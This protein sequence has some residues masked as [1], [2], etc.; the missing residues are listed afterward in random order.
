MGPTGPIHLAI[1]AVPAAK[2]VKTGVEW[3][4]WHL[5]RVMN[6]LEPELNVTV[7]THRPLDIELQG[8]WRN[9][10]IRAPKGLWKARFSLELLR[11]RP[12]V[13]FVPGDALP[14]IT[15]GKIVTTVHDLAFLSAPELYGVREGARQVRVH[16]RALVRS[17]RLI[18]ISGVTRQELMRH[19]GVD[20]SCIS[21]I[22]L[23]IDHT[24]YRPEARDQLSAVRYKHNLPENYFAFMG[25]LDARKGVANLIRAFL[26][27]RKDQT[28][29]L[30]GAPGESGYDEIHVLAGNEGVRE[31]GY[32][33][34]EDAAA[35]VSGAKAFV[36]PTKKEGFGMPIVEA[37]AVGTPVVCS[38][39]AVLREVGGDVP[40][41]VDAGS[42]AAWH[43]AFEEVWQHS[44]RDRVGR[45][46]ERAKSFSW[47]EAARATL[48]VLCNI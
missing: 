43:R 15:V 7:Y 29:V 31:L 10:V 6:A 12:D 40:I 19:F 3:Y 18:A 38:D 39:L 27:W 32:V 14:I 26:S 5:I 16:R 24:V 23:G 1:D 48:D 30:M 37:M 35:I 8:V 11:D 9:K 13:L 44:Q 46:M 42:E 41:F 45:G 17:A 47:E 34:P 4:V 25:R 33:S 22:P 36:F 21:V 20:E 2:P 28:L